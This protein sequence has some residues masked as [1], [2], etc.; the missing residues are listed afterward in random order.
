V[1]EGVRVGD[2][3]ILNPPVTLENGDK[4]NVR[5]AEKATATK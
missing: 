3:V 2:E 5:P 1:R 4:V